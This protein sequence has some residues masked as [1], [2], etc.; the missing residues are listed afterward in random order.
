MEQLIIL[1]ALAVYALIRWLARQRQETFPGADERA[2]EATGEDG[3]LEP[4]QHPDSLQ[5]LDPPQPVSLP[6]E[7]LP[8]PSAPLEGAHLPQAP[9]PL[10]VLAARREREARLRRVAARRVQAVAERPG[11]KLPGAAITTV[12]PGDLGPAGLR[13][14]MVLMTVLGPPRALDP[15]RPS[16][17]AT[18]LG[19][20]PARTFR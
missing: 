11:A 5:R 19:L 7:P 3:V 16:P 20:P 8:R 15:P 18:P 1:A 14:A 6:D 17:P 13:R 2:D 9:T 12:S 10:E 4:P